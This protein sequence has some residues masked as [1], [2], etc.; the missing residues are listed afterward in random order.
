LRTWRHVACTRILDDAATPLHGR[1]SRESWNEIEQFI[2]NKKMWFLPDPFNAMS[3]EN[4]WRNV[5]IPTCSF[6]MTILVRSR[7]QSK[8]HPL[9]DL[10]W[11]ILFCFLFSTLPTAMP[12]HPTT[13][14]TF[15]PPLH[16]HAP[17]IRVE[18]RAIDIFLHP[19]TFHLAP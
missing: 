17:T 5:E 14:T 15:H 19:P 11:T 7:K 3:A 18:T 6:S 13:T 9:G 4:H 2:I 1:N 16:L 12:P 8:L 10:T